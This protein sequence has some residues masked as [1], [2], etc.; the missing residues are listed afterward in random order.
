MLPLGQNSSIRYVI[1]KVSSENLDSYLIASEALCGSAPSSTYM[2]EAD[3][4]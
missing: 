4:L 1:S 3:R 2:G